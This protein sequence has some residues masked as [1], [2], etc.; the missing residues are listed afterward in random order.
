MKNQGSISISLA[1]V[2]KFILNDSSFNLTEKKQ[3]V[4]ISESNNMSKAINIKRNDKNEVNVVY[5]FNN[6]W[7]YFENRLI[8]NK[9]FLSLSIF[10]G[11]SHDD[12]KTQLFRAEWDNYDENKIHP[13]P[14]WHIYP[15]KYN[16]QTHEDFETFIGFT[17]EPT[18][19]D[20]LNNNSGKIV[21]ISKFH[22]AINGN[23]FN[24]DNHIKLCNVNE[25]KELKM[26][27]NGLIIHI[28]EQL[29]YIV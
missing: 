28:K 13:Q 10:Q 9:I 20:V 7:I 23:W 3:N 19:E 16:S 26:W 4:F 15:H 17:S 12:K 18:F 1:E 24:G 21:D 11:E 27:L 2:F 5:W 22:F 14:H 8:D 6:F 29:E 25:E